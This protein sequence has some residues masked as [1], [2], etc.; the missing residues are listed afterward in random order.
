MR[1]TGCED[2]INA[3]SAA[4]G[5]P[6][7]NRPSTH[8]VCDP[9]TLSRWCFR[10]QRV[11]LWHPIPRVPT[12]PLHPCAVPHCPTLLPRGVSRCPQ[13]RRQQEQ[14][15]GSFRER[16]Y[17]A[18]W[19]VAARR[20]RREFPLCGMRPNG[21]APVMSK[22]HDEHRLTPAYQTD[23]VVPHRG[24]Q[25]LF[26]DRDGNWQSLCRECGARKSQAGL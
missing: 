22:C 25:T 11:M 10:L 6:L 8:A 16:G 12:A 13:H 19:D 14:A 7:G 3:A 9:W 17:T 26:W 2:V 18:K 15:R 5:G 1:V 20:F 24:D 23:H 4:T 21:L